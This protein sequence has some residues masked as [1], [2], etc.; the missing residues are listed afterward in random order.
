MKDYFTTP[1]IAE[2]C[3]VDKVTVANWIRSGRLKSYATAGSENR[4]GRYR[5]KKQ[6]LVNFFQKQGWPVPDGLRLS[7][8]KILIVDDEEGIIK[9]IKGLLEN[10]SSELLIESE[11]CPIK[12]GMKLMSF[13][14]DLVL[15][16]VCLKYDSSK[17]SCELCRFIKE[18]PFLSGTKIIVITGY[19]HYIPNLMEAGADDSMKKPL[20]AKELE[21]K[22]RKFLDIDLIPETPTEK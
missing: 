17:E 20:D 16:D 15:L 3:N 9:I 7:K 1:E 2:I 11:T 4:S 13:L 14:P 12:A 18:Q 5:I 6:D 19:P 8:Y 22:V 10:I 21:I